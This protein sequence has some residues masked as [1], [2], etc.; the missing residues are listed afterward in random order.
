M[1]L[2]GMAKLP[3]RKNTN[4]ASVAENGCHSFLLWMIMA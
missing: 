1:N 4:I 3:S 2:R